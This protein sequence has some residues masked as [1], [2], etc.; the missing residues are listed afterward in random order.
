MRIARLLTPALV[1]AFLPT[2][3]FTSASTADPPTRVGRLSFLRGAVSFRP[4]GEDDWADASLNYPLTTGDHLWS[5]DDGRSEVSLGSTA[6]RLARYTAVG[7]L[8]LDDHTSQLRLSQGSVQV[9]LRNLEEDDSFEIDTPNGAISLLRPGSYV[10]D[11]D[12]TGDTTIVTVR[13]GEA[14]VTAAGSSFSVR[15][16]QAATLVGTDWPTYDVH[17]P[18]APDA[19]EDWCASRDRRAD[20]ARSAS[21][22]SRDMPGYEDLGH[23]TATA[24]GPGSSRGAGR[25]S[26]TRR[27]GSRRFTTAAGSTGRAA[28][29]GCRVAWWPCGPCTRP[30]WSC[31][32]AAAGRACTSGWAE[33]AAWVGSRS[34]RGRCTSPAT[35]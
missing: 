35:A 31:S 5:D 34:R 29:A 26:T 7:F 19:W 30:R 15:Y 18:L 10:V 9:R 33:A 2:A 1:L 8:E 11:V 25:G 20:N 28:G 14:E 21:Y 16:D 24:T 6:I 13:R 4:A 32:W 22:V 17:D 23:R 27:G 3:G 12:S